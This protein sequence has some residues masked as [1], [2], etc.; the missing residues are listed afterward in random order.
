M[1][2]AHMTVSAKIWFFSKMK[3]ERRHIVAPFDLRLRATVPLAPLP[4]PLT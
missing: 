3:D 1:A 2:D 4:L